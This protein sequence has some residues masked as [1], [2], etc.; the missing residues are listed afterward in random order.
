MCRDR[1]NGID[2]Y[3][4]F[5]TREIISGT[6]ANHIVEVTEDKDLMFDINN[7]IWISDTSHREIHNRYC[8]E[9]EKTQQ[10]LQQMIAKYVK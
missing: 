10:E 8:K 2:I 3:N 6:L 9:K 5:K 7:L 1:F 4:Y